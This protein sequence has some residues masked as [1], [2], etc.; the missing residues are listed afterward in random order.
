MS[1]GQNHQIGWRDASDRVSP[2]QRRCLKRMLRKRRRQEE[3]YS[4]EEAPRKS[5]YYAHW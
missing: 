4:P 1:Y 3:R 2:E 5:R